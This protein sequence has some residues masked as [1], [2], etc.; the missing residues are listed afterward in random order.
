MPSAAELNVVTGAFGYTG[1]YIARRLLAN[2]Y[3][4]RTLTS[5]PSR[6][7]EFANRVE[8]APLDFND[9]RGLRQSLSGAAALFNTYWIRFS[10][11]R[12]T[13]ERAIENSRRLI[14][15][16]ADAGVRRIVQISIMNPSLDSPLPYFR[17]KALVE[18]AIRRSGLSHAILRPTVIFGTG[19]I[20]INNIAWLLRR[21]PVFAVPCTGD[22]RL[23]PIF[24]EDLAEQALAAA[25]V[26]ENLVQDAV[27]PETFTFQELVQAIAAA[28]RSRATIL[29]VRPGIA[30]AT[31][32]ILG[33]FTRDVML[34]RDEVDGLMSNLLVSSKPPVGRTPFTRWVRENAQHLGKHYASEL[35]RHY[36]SS[37]KRESSGAT[38]LGEGGDTLAGGTAP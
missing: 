12:A 22:Y 5:H 16:A 34:T 26:E 25:Q 32:H 36:R 35:A 10:H 11:G 2:G 23:Q 20:L 18:Q 7:N 28:V 27:G 24:V 31:A 30:L 1:S 33:W 37:S 19:D 6:P 9:P 21:F 8:V 14:R 29:C 4:V 38:W 15:A 3:R 13:F 17:G